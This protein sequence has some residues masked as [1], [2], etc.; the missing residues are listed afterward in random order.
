MFSY[1]FFPQHKMTVVAMMMMTKTMMKTLLVLLY[2]RALT[3]YV[4][5]SLFTL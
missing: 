1:N 4:I 2:Q 5:L 3:T